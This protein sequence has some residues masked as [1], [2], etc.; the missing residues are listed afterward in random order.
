MK[1]CDKRKKVFFHSYW[2]SCAQYVS[3]VGHRFHKLFIRKICFHLVFQYD[4]FTFALSVDGWDMTFAITP[5]KLNKQL[6]RQDITF[7]LP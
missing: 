2:Y 5:V 1:T 3:T 7:L 4:K 6:Q